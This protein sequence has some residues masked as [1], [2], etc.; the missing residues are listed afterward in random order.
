MSVSKWRRKA[1]DPADTNMP[2]SRLI[3]RRFP[4]E[5]ARVPDLLPGNRASGLNSVVALASLS[6]HA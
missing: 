5:R 6:F 3:A 1:P 2:N 4:C